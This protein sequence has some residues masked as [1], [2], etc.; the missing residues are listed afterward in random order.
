MTYQEL[1]SGPAAQR[2]YWAR[3]HVGWT[4]MARAEPNAGH[5]AL[6]ELERAGGAAAG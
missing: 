3:S 1:L 2:R 4:R 6:A 5:R